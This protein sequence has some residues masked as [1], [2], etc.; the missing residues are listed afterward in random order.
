MA[1]FG[2]W[3]GRD[4]H[5][6]F[7][8]APPDTGVVF[9]RRD[10]PQPS[11]VPAL[12]RYRVET[13]RRTSLSYRGT[14]V[15]MIEHVLAALTGLRID[16]CE[17][18]V[19]R[20]EIPGCDGSSLDFVQALDAAGI[21]EQSA[22]R[23]VYRIEKTIRVG[24]D[25]SWVEARPSNDTNWT[26]R[27]DLDY[28]DGPIGQQSV[29]VVVT[30]ELFRDQL[31]SARTFLLQEEADW[32][33]QRGLGNRVTAKDL[34]VF[35]RNGPVENTLRFT[36][37]CARHKALDLI[38]DLALLG[39]D[40]IGHVRAHRAGHKLNADLVRALEQEYPDA[41]TWKRSA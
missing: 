31:A 21:V 33:R 23:A 3:S 27:Y 4:V 36:D 14:S 29:E 22:M 39:R 11:R 19:D 34:L 1:G 37:E 30:P 26:V 25:D 16:N 35:D 20:P 9:V 6:E 18:W 40:L 24:S 7:R 17:V 8:P 15:E 38:G 13:P 12:L 2:Y 10:L 28:G 41:V 32:L 5:L